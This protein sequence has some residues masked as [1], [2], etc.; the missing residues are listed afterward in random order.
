MLYGISIFARHNCDWE[1]EAQEKAQRKLKS[2]L[3]GS[4]WILPG[5]WEIILLLWKC[6]TFSVILWLHFFLQVLE[7]AQQVAVTKYGVEDKTNLYIRKSS[8]SY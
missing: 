8:L 3:R 5:N 7:E 1:T 6:H 4:S 2:E